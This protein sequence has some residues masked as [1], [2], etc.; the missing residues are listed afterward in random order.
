VIFEIIAPGGWLIAIAYNI[1]DAQRLKTENPGCI[2][3]RVQ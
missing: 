3:M 1:A 2:V